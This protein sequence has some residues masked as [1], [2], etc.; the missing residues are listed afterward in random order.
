MKTE[1]QIVKGPQEAGRGLPR[2]SKQNMLREWS[3]P[4]EAELE[5]VTSRRFSLRGNAAQELAH[6]SSLSSNLDSPRMFSLPRQQTLVRR[7]TR[8]SNMT[9]QHAW[10][11]VVLPLQHISF[12][13]REVFWAAGSW[14]TVSRSSE[15][16]LVQTQWN[17]PGPA[18]G[19]Q[20]SPTKTTSLAQKKKACYHPIWP[21]EMKL[22]KHP[23]NRGRP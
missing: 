3:V 2:D 22:E 23:Q 5:M 19:L 16:G 4:H 6:A 10:L 7:E 8:P 17:S 15:H 14:L 20:A 9:R 1:L 11:G 12:T 18:F 21:L 13:F